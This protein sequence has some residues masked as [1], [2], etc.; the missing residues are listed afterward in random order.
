MA[1]QITFTI[2]EQ[3]LGKVDAEFTVKIDKQTLGTL[4]ISKGSLDWT[5]AGYSHENPFR[6]SWTKFDEWMR[7]RQNRKK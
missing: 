4:K 5:P 6:V 2:P 7:N 1:H 3:P